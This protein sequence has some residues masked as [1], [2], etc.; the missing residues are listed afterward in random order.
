MIPIKTDLRLKRTPYANYALIAVN[1]FI[2]LI[3]FA[4][5]PVKYEIK[6]VTEPLKDWAQ[7]FILNSARPQLWQFVTYGFLHSS[8]QHIIGNMFFL[9]L[10]GNNVNDRLGNT[11]YISFYIA[12]C[13]FAGIG[14][15][16]LHDTP[17]LGASGAV[18]AVTGAYLVLYP[19]SVITI[20][21][22][23][24][25]IGTIDVPAIWFI[26]LK[27]VLIDNVIQARYMSAPI[28]YDAH[29]AGYAFGFITP[30]VL[31]WTGLLQRSKMDMF[32]MLKQWYRRRQFREAL[33]QSNFD[34]ETGINIH[35]VKADS[36]QSPEEQ[37][38]TEQ[39]YKLRSEIS[40][41]IIKKRLAEAANKYIELQ[42]TDSGQILPLREQ[43]DVSNYLMASNRYK[44]ASSAYKDF[45]K[46]YPTY[47]YIEQ[48]HLMLGVIYARYIVDK[49]LAKKY[50]ELALDGLEEPSQ[51]KMCE[52]ELKK[53][54]K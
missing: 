28:A 13:I 32:G 18:S 6:I 5:H 45:I 7:T 17:V 8:Y 29:L 44:Q 41:L 38:K 51:K 22:W 33:K 54:S 34:E 16:L 3:T 12:G 11:G 21:Y 37:Q 25:I 4:P 30:M 49:D 19:R 50:L 9:Y 1:V 27:M 24:V 14:Y 10:F 35:K 43:L 2:F 20:L 53:I 36:D 48:I 52:N 39:I 46:A 42:N 23:F 47:S 40:S 26:L 31:L 15:S